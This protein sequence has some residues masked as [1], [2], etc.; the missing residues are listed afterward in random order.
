MIS[1]HFFRVSGH[2]VFAIPVL[3]VDN[4]QQLFLLTSSFASRT[5]AIHQL[6]SS[7][8]SISSSSFPHLYQP[9]MFPAGQASINSSLTVAS[10]F[11]DT[12]QGSKS[13]YR[14]GSVRLLNHQ[15]VADMPPLYVFEDHHTPPFPSQ[16][17]PGGEVGQFCTV[18]SVPTLVSFLA[19][20]PIYPH[21]T[22]SALKSSP[23]HCPWN[24]FLVPVY[25]AWRQAN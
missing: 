11:L 18:V 13:F 15:P 8:I 23:C 22:P 12:A 3:V 7:S 21:A 24:S 6:K 14:A 4:T 2:K 9:P 17:L 16:K 5:Q 19:L 10:W 25:W 1:C 20:Q